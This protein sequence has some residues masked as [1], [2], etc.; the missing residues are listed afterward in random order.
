MGRCR[1][2]G[3]GAALVLAG[4]LLAGGVEGAAQAGQLFLVR[5]EIHGGNFTARVQNAGPG[6]VCGIRIVATW[7]PADT[8]ARSRKEVP[9]GSLEVGE[10]KEFEL[11]DVVVG[12]TP[13]D[14]EV[15]GEPCE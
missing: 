5:K 4:L 9:I 14:L 3:R 10:R 1:I 12:G 7:R 6:R 2:W 8:T 15:F 11:L 13:P